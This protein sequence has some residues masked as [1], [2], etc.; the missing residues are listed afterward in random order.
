MRVAHIA[1]DGALELNWM[2]LPTFIGQN[3]G[4]MRELQGVWAARFK[5]QTPTEEILE[6]VHRFTI[7]W[8]QE[9]LK[10]PG[11]NDYLSAITK[12]QQ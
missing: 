4:L 3:F 9:K 11:L 1:K 7:N 12:V 2:W 5:G 8:L 10:I 6:E